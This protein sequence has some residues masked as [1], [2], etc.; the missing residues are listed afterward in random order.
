MKSLFIFLL[1]ILFALTSCTKRQN[2][3][4]VN[5]TPHNDT[6]WLIVEYDPIKEQIATDAN[7]ERII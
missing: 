5:E 1:A 6:T 2:Q 7:I 4:E 3:A